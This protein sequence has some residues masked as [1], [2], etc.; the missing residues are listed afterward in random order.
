MKFPRTP[1]KSQDQFVLENFSEVINLAKSIQTPVEREEI[2]DIARKNP[3]GVLVLITSESPNQF[4]I[5]C[6]NSVRLHYCAIDDSLHEVE[7][8]NSWPHYLDDIKYFNFAPNESWK[9][10]DTLKKLACSHLAS[11]LLEDKMV[12]LTRSTN[13]FY[14]V[15]MTE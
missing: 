7:G 14:Q 12:V 13:Y 10:L 5:I 15:S 3:L 2:L 9:E 8:A 6:M 4:K 1:K 11:I